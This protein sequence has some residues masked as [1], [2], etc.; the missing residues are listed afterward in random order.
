M[1]DTYESLTSE[2]SGTWLLFIH[3]VP[4]KPDYLR[5][6]IRRRLHRLGALPLKSTVYA[7][8]DTRPSLVAF[9]GLAAEIGALGGS[10]VI[11]RGTFVGGTAPEEP[12]PLG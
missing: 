11:C 5:V 10:A 7:L 8:P 1:H 4:P 2:T 3:Q 12:A 6:K 9:H